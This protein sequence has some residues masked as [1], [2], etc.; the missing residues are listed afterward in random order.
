MK[1]T[2]AKESIKIRKTELRDCL[3]AYNTGTLGYS[4][5]LRIP[6]RI[7]INKTL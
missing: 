6:A 5:K 7:Y 3:L 2:G 4:S 1:I